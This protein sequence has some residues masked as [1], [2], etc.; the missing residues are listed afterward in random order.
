MGA[1]NAST[2]LDATP[3]HFN[4]TFNGCIFDNNTLTT[5]TLLG[6][7]AMGLF[8]QSGAGS[9][10]FQSCSF[11]NNIVTT[12]EIEDT[13]NFGGGGGALLIRGNALPLNVTLMGCNMVSNSAENAGALLFQ[14]AY[15]VSY[16]EEQAH[17]TI[18]NSTFISNSATVDFGG[19]IGFFG[20]T[21]VVRNSIFKHNNAP[22]VA[23]SWINANG[24]AIACDATV[25]LESVIFEENGAWFG[26][27]VAL[28]FASRSAHGSEFVNCSFVA[29][30]ATLGGAVGA[31]AGTPTG[32][33]LTSCNFE[34]NYASE[35]GVFSVTTGTSIEISVSKCIFLNNGAVAGGIFDLSTGSVLTM[36]DSDILGTTLI[37]Q[38]AE[39]GVFSMNG[40]SVTLND[41][42][43]VTTA[44]SYTKVGRK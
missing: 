22:G 30:Q 42:T 20:E 9:V 36:I 33:R 18:L 5:S 1:I 14:G 6:G 28:V 40:G 19:A 10:L 13:A 8:V 16:V 37:S 39:G 31:F 11:T 17:L 38:F 44:V 12:W 43:I 7:A 15:Y 34:G 4:F 27:A 21:L 35:G 3:F 32:V 25:F 29:N 2:P 23:R 26:G 41:T 24:G